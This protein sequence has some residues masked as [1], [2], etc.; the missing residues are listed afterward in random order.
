MNIDFDQSRWDRIRARHRAW[1]DGTTDQPLVHL[2]LSGR[3]PDRA[4]PRGFGA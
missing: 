1:W 2:T 4:E 3:D